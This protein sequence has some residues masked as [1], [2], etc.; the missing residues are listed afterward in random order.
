MPGFFIFPVDIMDIMC[1]NKA[2]LENGSKGG[3][4]K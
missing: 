4:I 3:Q 1:N 2:N